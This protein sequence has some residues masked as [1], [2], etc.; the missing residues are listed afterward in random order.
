LESKSQR[1]TGSFVVVAATLDVKGEEVAFLIDQLRAKGLVVKVI[2][3]GILGAPAFAAD[4]SNYDIALA[5]G[6]DLDDL[7]AIHNR[8]A[9]LPV[10]LRGLKVTMER[11]VREQQVCGYV[12]IGGGTNAALAAVA[13]EAM[14]FGMPKLLLSTKASGWTRPVVGIKDVTLM[15]SVVDPMG[16][17]GFLRDMIRTA[18]AFV[19]AGLKERINFD[20]PAMASRTVGMTTFGATTEGARHAISV[21]AARGYETLAFHAQGTGGRAMEALVRDGR[22]TSILDLTITEIA[23]E[24]VGGVNDAGPDRLS[25]AADMGIP[26]VILPGAIDMINFAEPLTI[27]A[28]F[29]GRTFARHTPS[30]TLMR[31]S[32]NDNV[33]IARV[34]AQRLNRAKGSTFVVLPLRGFSSYDAP[35]GP[36]FDPAAD[37]AF[38][39]T[40]KAELKADIRV[41]TV[42][43]HINDRACIEVATAA[44][45][46][47]IR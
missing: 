29:S 31:S 43:A 12:G 3:C 16:L 6:G 42:D 46:R 25:A 38:R 41:E 35:G 45:L 11:L 13:F 20:P 15:Y 44:L 47:M 2:D 26:Q 36:F 19:A 10:M 28:R 14:P 34:V 4:I 32:V 27:P 30:A 37:E 21:L 1:D 40:L 8:E 9:A 18:A 24:V 33:G 23:D 39:E 17:N 5:G 7:R 22:I